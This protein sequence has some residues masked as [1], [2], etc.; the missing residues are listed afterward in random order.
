MGGGLGDDLLDSLASFLERLCR[1]IVSYTVTTKTFKLDKLY[2]L[3][4][5]SLDPK[6]YYGMIL[7]HLNSSI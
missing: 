7:S 3:T 1:I 5:E 4:P 6:K 2:F